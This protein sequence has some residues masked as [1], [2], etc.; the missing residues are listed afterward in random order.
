[1]LF[2]ISASAI[3]DAP[4]VKDL[5]MREVRTTNIREQDRAI[6][7]GDGVLDLCRGVFVTTRSA[8]REGVAGNALFC[9]GWREALQQI[10]AAPAGTIPVVI[11]TE[12]DLTSSQI[13][14]D[15]YLPKGQN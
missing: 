14:L 4:E 11:Y 13:T 6:V 9:Q 12:G 3:L 15:D 8:A 2:Q 7:I 5:V 10:D 1:M